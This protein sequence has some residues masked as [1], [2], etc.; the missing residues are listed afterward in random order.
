MG[1]WSWHLSHWTNKRLTDRGPLYTMQSGHHWGILVVYAYTTLSRSETMLGPKPQPYTRP[2]YE[3]D[4]DGDVT[5]TLVYV[6]TTDEAGM[7]IITNISLALIDNPNF[8]DP[9][10]GGTSEKKINK[11]FLAEIQPDYIREQ[12]ELRDP[13]TTDDSYDVS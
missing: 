11:L 10:R 12:V 5:S 3:I 7:L 13:K 1:L 8:V 6:D 2:E 4:E 9:K